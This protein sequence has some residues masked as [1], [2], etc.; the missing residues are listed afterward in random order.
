MLWAFML[1]GA[2]AGAFII[3]FGLLGVFGAAQAITRPGRRAR[4]R[5]RPPLHHA[6][7]WGGLSTVQLLHG[8]MCCAASPT[9]PLPRSHELSRLGASSPEPRRPCT[10]LPALRVTQALLHALSARC[11]GLGCKG[12]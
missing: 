10:S 8:A 4:A 12:P 7:R 3:L 5:L 9:A 6:Q 2:V 1:G 11:K